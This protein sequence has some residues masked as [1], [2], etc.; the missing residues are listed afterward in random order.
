MNKTE[1][2][3]N[4]CLSKG[5]YSTEKRVKEAVKRIGKERQVKLYYYMCPD[6]LGFHL[7]RQARE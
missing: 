7:T 6:C 3:L 4:R 5:K 2:W 1:K